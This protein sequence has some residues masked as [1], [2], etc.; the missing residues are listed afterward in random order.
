MWPIKKNPVLF[1]CDFRFNFYFKGFFTCKIFSISSRF[2]NVCSQSMSKFPFKT[3]R[4]S[5]TKGLFFPYQRQC[6]FE[7]KLVMY[8]NGVVM[9]KFWCHPIGDWTRHLLLR[10]GSE[11]D[12]L[13]W[14]FYVL[15]ALRLILLIV[16]SGNQNFLPTSPA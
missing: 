4:I 1:L 5:F 11:S 9:S 12:E 15:Y 16:L 14:Q 7:K 10:G 3:F 2:G 8:I 6:Y 13:P